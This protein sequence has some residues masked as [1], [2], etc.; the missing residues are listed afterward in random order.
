MQQYPSDTG[1]NFQGQIEEEDSAA[2][3]QSIFNAVE[4]SI[5]VVDVLE[6]RDFRYASANPTHERW[7]GQRSSEIKG[8][9]PEQILPPEQARVVRQHYKDCLRFGTAISY[10]Q[11][12]PSRGVPYWWLTTVT[13]LSDAR[14]RVYRLVATSID[15]TERK[16]A[17]ETLRLQARREQ[18]LGVMQE[19]I[20]QSLDLD[21]I[22]QRTVKEVRQFLNCDRVLIYRFFPDGS[23]AIVVESHDIQARSVLG[24]TV[25]DPCFSLS[26][27]RV[28]SYRKR[29][30][31]AIEDVR[32]AG[33]HPCYRD[34]LASLQVRANLV[35]PIVSDLEGYLETDAADSHLWGLLIAQHCRE[36]RQWQQPEIDLLQQLALQVA[37]AIRHAE[38]HHRAKCLNVAL[39]SR[40]QQRTAELQ[41]RWKYEAMVKRITE[42]IRDSLD[43]RQILQTATRELV[44]VLQVERARIELY[45][46]DRST[47]TIAYETI[48]KPPSCQGITR[49]VADCPEIY[50][51]LLRKEVLQ[52]V[53]L[54]PFDHPDLDRVTWLAC[55]IFDDR[56]FLGNLWLVRP[57]AMIFNDL[58][59]QLVRQIADE[60]AIAIRQARLYESSRTQLREMEKLERLKNE[61]LKTISHELRTPITSIRLAAETL[62]SFLEQKGILPDEDNSIGELLRILHGECQRQG[63]IID[64]LLTLTYLDAETTSIVR[65]EVDLLS[66]L[67]P[68]AKGFRE[69]ARE[70]EQEL[71]IDIA[72]DLPCIRTDI[73]TLD[74]VL[75]ELLT[76]ACKYTPSGGAIALVASRVADGISIEVR[77]WGAEIPADELPRIF[78]PFYRIPKRDPWRYGGTGLGLA[79]VR[80]LVDRLHAS[81]GVS[82]LDRLTVFTLTLPL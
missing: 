39:E 65:E 55:P 72:A 20:R 18:L 6:N 9:T 22:L 28:N 25:Q 78:D 42:R 15:I 51:S 38:L 56:G 4:A 31:Q 68:L 21:R 19:R 54:L 37:I 34:F 5:V 81:I 79:L 63:K 8:K 49:Q 32:V 53:N 74:R 43:E 80:K 46:L 3:L 14:G 75:R 58:E 67:P 40:V 27:D 1:R 57:S 2:F 76:N 70:R 82:S 35:V 45:N 47:A 73:A 59:I 71:V 69:M 10:E 11:Y 24:T 52:F 61:F 36:P 7:T 23:G 17:E 62:E 12:L 41:M 13:P 60:C 26:V 66:W 77:N 50:R 29:H 44:Q 16:Q 33:L 64:D 30:I 48:L